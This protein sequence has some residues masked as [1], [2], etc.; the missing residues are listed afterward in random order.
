M[1]LAFTTAAAVGGAL[2]T[3]RFAC[4]PDPLGLGS[5][6]ACR[7]TVLDLLKANEVERRDSDQRR[8][9]NEGSHVLG[10]TKP[11]IFRFPLPILVSRQIKQSVNIAFGV[12]RG[13]LVA[14]LDILTKPELQNLAT[15]ILFLRWLAARHLMPNAALSSK[16]RRSN[17][18]AQRGDPR[19]WQQPREATNRR[20]VFSRCCCAF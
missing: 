16:V 8:K 12:A 17:L 6:T 2:A 9:Q 20:E 3:A 14:F 7:C 15:A 18:K 13:A 11:V 4:R 10:H 19:S 1:V 5:A